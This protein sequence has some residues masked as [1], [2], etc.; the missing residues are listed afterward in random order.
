[1]AVA[2]ISVSLKR[3]ISLPR[4]VH[5][6]GGADDVDHFIQIL[7]GDQI[8][9]QDVG[10]LSGSFQIEFRARLMTVSRCSI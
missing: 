10:A 2:C 6:G 3:F 4:R 5:V 1:M 8:A 9:L 7:Q